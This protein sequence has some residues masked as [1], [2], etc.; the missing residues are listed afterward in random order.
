[1]TDPTQYD[2]AAPVETGPKAS[3]VDPLVEGDHT[4]HPSAGDLIDPDAP[5]DP[6]YHGPYDPMNGYDDQDHPLNAY[7]R[8]EAMNTPEAIAAELG[9]A[10]QDD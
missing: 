2:P 1:M 9:E 4:D 10:A 8:S 3:P 6:A 7:G 5:A